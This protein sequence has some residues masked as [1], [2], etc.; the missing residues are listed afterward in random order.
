MGK[1]AGTVYC[2]ASPLLCSQQQ[3]SPYRYFWALCARW[4]RGGGRAICFRI[5]KQYVTRVRIA[6]AA[7]VFTSYTR[8]GGGEGPAAAR[9]GGRWTVATVR[10]SGTDKVAIEIGPPPHHPFAFSHPSIMY[11]HNIII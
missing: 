4:C 8:H 10:R 2:S 7:V 3:G 1:N 11:T 6:S 9:A 5:L